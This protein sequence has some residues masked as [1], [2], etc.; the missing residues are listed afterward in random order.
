MIKSLTI[1][2]FRSIKD[3]QV[4]DLTALKSKELHKEN[5]V[6]LENKKFSVLKS[7]GIYGANASGKSN[8]LLA[9]RALEYMITE[10]SDWKLD[11]TIQCYEPFKFDKDTRNAPCMFE[12]EFIGDD[13]LL[14]IYRVEFTVD[15]I[16]HESLSFYPTTQKANLFFRSIDEK[17]NLKF[18]PGTRLKGKVKSIPCLKNNLYLSKAANTEGAPEILK[19]IYRYFKNRI[20]TLSPNSGVEARNLLKDEKQRK[21]MTALLACADTGITGIQLKEQDINV[22][23]LKLPDDLPEPVKKHIIETNKYKL[24]F[25]HHNNNECELS[26]EEESRGTQ[27]LFEL[28][29]LLLVG[30]QKG[31]I[32]IIDEIDSS[33]HPHI[34]E[35]LIRLF[36]D[37]LINKNSAQLIFTTH[38]MTLMNADFMRRDQIVLTEKDDDGSSELFS[39]DGIEGV[40]KDSPYAKWYMDGRMG[41]V[42]RLDIFRLK[43]LLMDEA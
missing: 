33:L 5:I 32:I 8:V 11:E 9:F 18:T 20:I 39:L 26:M 28:S 25:F 43:Q 4:L 17:G 16:I 23:S 36:H 15:A 14:Y 42:P 7:V 30:L 27:R 3:E 12:I 31:D 13:K 29:P 35:L 19:D 10:S 34:S 40:R 37:P 2:N 6:P 41:A 21:A 38:D 1:K 22:D 24:V